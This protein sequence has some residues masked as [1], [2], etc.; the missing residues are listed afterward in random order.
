MNE[1]IIRQ[2]VAVVVAV[3]LVTAAVSLLN[4]WSVARNESKPSLQ[5]T[6]LV[7]AGHAQSGS[8]LPQT[9]ART[10]SVKAPALS[11]YS[12]AEC[13]SRSNGLSL[14]NS[15]QRTA[16]LR[17]VIQQ[18]EN[19]VDAGPEAVPA[20]RDYLRQGVDRQFGGRGERLA[21]SSLRSGLFSVLQR[22][23]GP[24]AEQTLL[25]AL[26]A[27]QS[28][29]ELRQLAQL[30]E[31]MAPGKYREASIARAHELAVQ[32]TSLAGDRG[33]QQREAAYEVLGR[34]GDQSLAASAQGELITSSGKLDETAL[35]YLTRALGDQSFPILQ[36]ALADPR[37][38]DRDD[39]E[40]LVEAIADR[41]NESPQAKLALQQ[42]AMDSNLGRRE[43]DEAF[44]ALRQAGDTSLVNV[45]R[46][47]VITEEGNINESAL[48]YL[49]RATGDQVLNEVLQAWSDPRVRNHEEREELVQ[50]IAGR[51]GRNDNANLMWQ[52][53]VGNAQMPANLR[54][55]AI[56]ELDD[57][58]IN[59]R[60]PTD[61]DRQ[62]AATRMR[63]LE[64][65]A[66]QLQ[67]PRLV[68]RAER[69]YGEL[70]KVAQPPTP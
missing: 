42:I 46:E 52:E 63:L 16:G 50:V 56:G 68:S 34:A 26:N 1:R 15:S 51:V 57:R 54:E 66:S 21:P 40:E 18:L 69:V 30:L 65:V 58:G 9:P 48:R 7:S 23:G 8:A 4:T 37:L 17:T 32:A 49:E 43:R 60:R 61:Q 3:A 59:R 45:A 14:T 10:M 44:D 67:D 36:Q 53:I 12:P 41:M 6:E 55:E 2:V 5:T 28:G 64:Q 38:K 47:R 39:K 13:L 27:T 29:P 24:E 31:D 22:I 11:P 35:R 62:L 33:R 70:S 20:I 19:L 25:E